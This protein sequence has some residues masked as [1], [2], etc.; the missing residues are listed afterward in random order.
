ME[1]ASKKKKEKETILK[2]K[3][4]KNL[5]SEASPRLLIGNSVIEYRTVLQKD[6]FDCILFW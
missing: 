2:Q 3:V 4:D 1:T 6:G 5:N